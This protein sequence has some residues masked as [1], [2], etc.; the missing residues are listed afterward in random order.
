MGREFKNRFARTSRVSQAQWIVQQIMALLEC[1]ASQI[2]YRKLPLEKVQGHTNPLFHSQ[3]MAL[4]SAVTDPRTQQSA[5]IYDAICRKAVPL[6]EMVIKKD[7]GS[8]QLL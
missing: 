6:M 1:S 7:R 4:A 5:Q 2:E 3:G 8:N